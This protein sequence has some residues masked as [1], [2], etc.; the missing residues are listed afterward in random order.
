MRNSIARAN[1]ATSARKARVFRDG[2]A[3]PT[4]DT[5]IPVSCCNP[6]AEPI[7]GLC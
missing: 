4:T 5:G 1:R 7:T 3:V 2:K 6:L